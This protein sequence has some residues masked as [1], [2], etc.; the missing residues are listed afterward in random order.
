MKLAIKLSKALSLSDYEARVYIVLQ[1]NGPLHI[2]NISKYSLLPRTA[3][4]PP[5]RGL[6][7]RGLVSESVFGKR[8]YYSALPPE[9]LRGIMEEKR[10][11]IEETIKELNET[12]KISSDSA[13]LETTFYVGIQGIKSAGLVFLNETKEKVWYSFENLGKITDSIGLD[14]EAFYVKE[15]MKRNIESRMILS[16]TETSYILDKFIKQ[17][18][19]Q[20]RKTVILSPNEYPFDTTV[21]VTK[22][23]ILMI[24]P[25]ENQFALLVRNTHLA[26]TFINIHKCIWDRYV[27]K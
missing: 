24:N 10:S 15:R 9:N 19:E 14:F 26:D 3:V 18:S 5:L 2:K 7:T 16:I 6:V 12:R 17:D 23:L 25:N 22:G 20:L 11:L 13:K 27:I 8:R 21:V 4:Y 1:N